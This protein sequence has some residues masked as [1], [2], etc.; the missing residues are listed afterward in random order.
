MV[1]TTLSEVLAIHYGIFAQ[2]YMHS[3]P[4]TPKQFV[5]YVRLQSVSKA[6]YHIAKAMATNTTGNAAMVTQIRRLKRFQLT[7]YALRYGHHKMFTEAA[8]L[9]QH[10]VW[11][12]NKNR[13][14]IRSCGHSTGIWMPWGSWELP[15]H[16]PEG[17]G[18]HGS[19]T[20]KM[21]YLCS[22]QEAKKAGSNYGK[23][24]KKNNNELHGAYVVCSRACHEVAKYITQGF[25]PAPTI[26]RGVND[27]HPGDLQ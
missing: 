21:A 16:G 2:Y 14:A 18:P 3:H 5:P 19:L 24:A 1:K 17:T 27:C 15:T 23:W 25:T 26:Y 12:P 6:L 22:L 10:E 8:K 9:L 20:I 4:L 11:E 13:C 7:V